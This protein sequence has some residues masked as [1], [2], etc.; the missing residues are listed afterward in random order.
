MKNLLWDFITDRRRTPRRMQRPEQPEGSTKSQVSSEGA[1]KSK[2]SLPMGSSLDTRA[3]GMMGGIQA[4]G[5]AVECRCWVLSLLSGLGRY[6]VET[7]GEHSLRG[8]SFSWGLPA[9][10]AKATI[11]DLRTNFC[12]ALP[13]HKCP[14]HSRLCCCFRIKIC[15][16][17]GAWLLYLV[18]LAL[19]PCFSTQGLRLGY[20]LTFIQYKKLWIVCR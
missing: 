13:L 14:P 20:I 5:C 17:S 10:R 15:S 12:P 19:N 1:Q 8:Y 11:A 3:L 6:P 7:Q 18:V 9:S 2:P 4:E 16:G